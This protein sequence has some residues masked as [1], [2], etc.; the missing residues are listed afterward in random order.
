VHW[1]LLVPLIAIGGLSAGLIAVV[2][3]GAALPVAHT[4]GGTVTLPDPPEKVWEVITDVDGY[5]MWRPGVRSVKRHDDGTWQEYDGRQLTTFE[6][7]EST[8]PHRLVTRIAESGLPYGGTWTYL[9]DPVPDGGSTLTVT[10][11]GEIYHPILRF[12]SRFVL[13]HRATI[14]KYLTGLANR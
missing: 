11:H 8:P 13:G 2:V 4:A 10:E 6:V 12:V 7:V 1:T 9:L 14:D 3:I 5:P